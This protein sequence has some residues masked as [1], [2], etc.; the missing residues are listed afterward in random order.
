MKKPLQLFGMLLREEAG[1]DLVEYALIAVLLSLAGI[2]VLT[3]LGSRIGNN[4]N[5]IAGTL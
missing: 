4:F 3:T 2:G 1:Q 5:E